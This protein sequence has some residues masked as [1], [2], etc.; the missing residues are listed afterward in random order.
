MGRLIDFNALT[1][2]DEAAWHDLANRTA[3]PNPFVE[4][5]M[6][7]AAH[8]HMPVRGSALL[9][10]ETRDGWTGCLPVRRTGPGATRVVLRSWLHMY[11]FLGVPL[12]DREQPTAALGALLA[13]AVGASGSGL[14]VLD[15]VAGDGPLSVLLPEAL[16]EQD[17]VTVLAESHERATLHRTEGGGYLDHVG[18]HHQREARRLARRLEDEL[19]A[20][21]EVADRSADAGAVSVFLRLEASGWKGRQGT[22]MASRP[23]HAEFFTALCDN[24][25]AQG[26]LQLLALE[27]GGRTVAMKC[28]LAAGPGLFCFKIAQDCKLDRFSPGV[29]LE[30]ENVRLFHEERDE[31]FM[32]SC[33]A[34]DNVM[35]NRL[36]P[37]RRRIGT[38]VVAKRGLR[39]AMSASVFR[40]A[41]HARK[42][43]RAKRALRQAG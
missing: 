22:A 25:R 36:W 34:A 3:E 5:A 8:R 10:T 27:A 24:F 12:L 4:P 43:V 16:A 14:V 7:L 21:L 35:I 26:R 39:T 41:V 9:V 15:A 32:D 33:A 38:L 17:M 1:G 30:R 11:S 31:A 23:S 37:D 6:V 20:P 19:G 29:R 40:T 42:R 18:R 13:A 2:R 28:N